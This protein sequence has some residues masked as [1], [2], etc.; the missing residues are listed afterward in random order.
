MSE[1]S[2][3]A[4]TGK[5][6]A[7]APEALADVAEFAGETDVLVVGFGCAG[8]AAAWEAATAGAEVLVLERASG[9]G[10][11]SGQS[12][13][14]LYLG[15][16]TRIQQACGFDDDADNMFAFLRRA[17]GP[18]AD[19]EKIRLYCDGSL[20]HFEWFCD[21]GLEFEERLYDAPTWMPHDTHGLMWLGENAWP[22][23][24]IASAVPRGHRTNVQGFGGFNIM[25][26]L[27]AA[28]ADA[29][30]QH[31]T[32]TRARSLIVDGDRVVGVTAR[33][34]G[35]DVAYRARR[36]V[37]VTTG[38]F[39]DNEQMLA[40]H[41]PDLVGHDKVSDGLDDGSGILMAAAHGA[42]TRRM[43]QVE[44]AYTALPA[45]VCRGMLV[46]GLGQR[47]INEDVYP[48]RWW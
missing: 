45:M 20:E 11:S 16:G 27:V 8:A 44:V 38:G 29:G 46:N 4:S 17:L 30:V 15:G 39:V 3:V 5:V 7:G 18:H 41:A 10:G 21:R 19:E 47:F 48:A 31:L 14:E 36:A 42:A 6:V 22:Y 9:P 12:G 34:F 33:S 25:E 32:D 40:D 13:G 23:N 43:S 28:C 35:A 24:E 37:I 1:Q 2:A 26:K